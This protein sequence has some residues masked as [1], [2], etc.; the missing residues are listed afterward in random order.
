MDCRFRVTPA[1]SLCYNDTMTAHIKGLPRTPKRVDSFVPTD[2]VYMDCLDCGQHYT[3]KTGLP[4]DGKR[5]LEL[6]GL[7]VKPCVGMPGGRM[8]SAVADPEKLTQ[9]QMD[10]IEQRVNSQERCGSTNYRI[11]R[12]MEPVAMPIGRQYTD[13]SRKHN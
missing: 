6:E 8:L 10:A 12:R 9:E 4:I 11:G 2:I 7:V 3:R 5:S 13:L 1:H